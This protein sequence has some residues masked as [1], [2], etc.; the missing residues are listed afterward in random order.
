MIECIGLSKIYRVTRTKRLFAVKSV[1]LVIKENTFLSLT[2]RSGSGKSTLIALIT[3]MM[4]PTEGEVI[5]DGQKLS[6]LEERGLTKLRRGYFGCI[7]QYPALHP[8]LTVLENVILP[9]VVTS[10]FKKEKKCA[11]ERYLSQVG[12]GNRMDHYPKQLSG[13]EVRRA[14]IA[15]A[16]IMEPEVLIADEP[17]ASLDRESAVQVLRLLKALHMSGKTVVV[18]SHDSLVENY[19]TEQA[20]MESGKLAYC[21]LTKYTSGQNRIK[22]AAE[23]PV[24]EQLSIDSEQKSR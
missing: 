18:A 19:A 23:S 24:L 20:R 2:G 12:L 16:L 3:G 10:L 8:S 7:R 1:D 13:G 21:G 5:V 14:A 6:D 9:L 11:A 22:E 17:T 4:P 15:R